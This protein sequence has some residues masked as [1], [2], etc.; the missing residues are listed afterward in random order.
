MATPATVLKYP[1]SKWT[2]ARWIVSHLPRHDVYVEPFFGSGAVFFSKGRC[3]LETVNDI[4]G[5][6]VNLFRVLRDDAPALCRAIALTP[7][8]R[9]EYE[10][11]YGP[12]TGDSVEDARRF[13]VR[14]WQAFG[15]RTGQRTG[16]RNDANAENR[17]ADSFMWATIPDRAAALV[18]RLQGVQIE[19]R[20]AVEVIG[21]HPYSNVLIYADPPY[22]S[23]TRSASIY[24]HEM[25]DSDHLAL[26][27]ALRAHPGPVV[28]SGYRNALYDGALSDWHRVDRTAIA[29]EGVRKVESLWLNPAADA[30]MQQR[31]PLGAA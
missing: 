28:L 12:D 23:E 5:R 13:L 21:R 1:G 3:R 14:C 18:K 22:M 11:S 8:S 15:T 6:V 26:L 20:P 31:L 9:E 2:L 29:E 30:G 27:D 16:W 24:A 4:D 10:A 7:W 25:S 19:C 17:G